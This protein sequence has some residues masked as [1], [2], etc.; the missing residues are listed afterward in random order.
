MLEMY[1]IVEDRTIA[2]VMDI[3]DLC[4]EYD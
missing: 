1:S 4:Y 2:E 3:S